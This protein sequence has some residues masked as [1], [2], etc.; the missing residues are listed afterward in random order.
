M[1]VAEGSAEVNVC[2]AETWKLVILRISEEDDG[3]AADAEAFAE[4]LWSGDGTGGRVCDA[5]TD[6]SGFVE[7]ASTAGPDDDC[8]GSSSIGC[9]GSGSTGSEAGVEAASTGAGRLMLID[10]SDALPFVL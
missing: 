7:D 8:G 1:L 3:F 2:M 5:G 9:A 6:G 10:A 4:A